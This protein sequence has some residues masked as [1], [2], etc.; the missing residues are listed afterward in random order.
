MKNK[1]RI[2]VSITTII[3]VLLILLGLTYDSGYIKNNGVALTK[4]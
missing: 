2:L 1:K 3:L 4:Y